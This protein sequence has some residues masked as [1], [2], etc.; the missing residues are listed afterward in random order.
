MLSLQISPLGCSTEGPLMA[1]VSARRLSSAKP[2]L[3]NAQTLERSVGITSFACRD[4]DG[5]DG[6]LDAARQ[7]R[8]YMLNEVDREGR[9]V[10]LLSLEDSLYR[11]PPR[12]PKQPNLTFTLYRS[13]LEV[14]TT[15]K[16]ISY[17]C[18]VPYPHLRVAGQLGPP[19]QGISVQ[20]VI[21]KKV[22]RQELLPLVEQ[23]SERTDLRCGNF[24]YT[25]TDELG[26]GHSGGERGVYRLSA[27]LRRV[28]P[29]AESKV[30]EMVTQISQ[31]GFLNYYGSRYFGRSDVKRHEV[32]L[33]VLQGDWRKAVGLLIG[34]NRREDSP[35]FEAWQA[36]QKGQMKDC[37]S[38]LPDTC[39]NLREMILTLIK[40]GDAREAYMSLPAVVR[41]QHMSAIGKFAFNLAADFRV[42]RM[43]HKV[44][45][46]DFVRSPAAPGGVSMVQVEDIKKKMWRLEDVLLPVLG[47]GVD[48]PDN[49]VAQFYRS[50]FDRFD[51]SP[52][53]LTVPSKP[54]L[55][56]TGFYRPA[57]SIPR[58]IQWDMV[59]YQQPHTHTHEAPDGDNA[60]SPPA[61]VPLLLCGLQR[62]KA[63]R[64]TTITEEG[65][66][67]E[68]ADAATSDAASDDCMLP[69][70]V[71]DFDSPG[72]ADGGVVGD[73]F[74]R[75]SDGSATADA[76][77]GRGGRGGGGRR[78]IRQKRQQDTALRIRATLDRHADGMMFLRE[79][80]HRDVSE[81]DVSADKISD[82]LL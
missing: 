22:S 8:D 10:Q 7:P 13:G 6:V 3:F 52:Q 51:L 60:G 27:A 5:F 62:L 78:S 64:R 72:G 63:L 14:Y 50:I 12:N 70:D 20:S 32:G 34:T 74:A 19:T 77:S 55:A 46:G 57:V 24:D 54:E 18:D 43:G 41:R 75:P 81:F 37:L 65:H 9:L 28:S 23:L 58:E 73:D 42:G 26:D 53:A 39:P 67:N 79:L 2:L 1:A 31:V 21:A 11:L 49:A 56:V 45:P 29:S 69:P 30:A 80:L 17:V 38:L 59:H 4:A 36:F 68:M 15:L 40:T 33:A 76:S 47:S 61:P 82:K 25:V 35:T 48:L 16:A 71:P 44:L 66:D